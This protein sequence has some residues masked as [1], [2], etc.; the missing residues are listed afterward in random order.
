MDQDELLEFR[1]EFRQ[2]NHLDPVQVREWLVKYPELTIR[3]MAEVTLLAPCTLWR[4]RKRAG[5]RKA[6]LAELSTMC[7]MSVK[8]A[9]TYRPRRVALDFE[10]PDDW[11]TNKE[12]LAATYKQIGLRL[13][14]RL[15]KCSQ[16][17][18]TFALLKAGIILRKKAGRSRNK[19][20]NREWI[21]EHYMRKRLTLTKCANLAGVSVATFR[22]WLVIFAVPVRSKYEASR[23]CHLS[24]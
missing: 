22:Q 20:F 11:A 16:T 2:V 6:Y 21:E 14:M 8:K 9:P 19:C 12:W 13:M 15:L 1:E 3:E 24:G 18:I 17:K 23:K 7:V 5:M 10:V 4:M